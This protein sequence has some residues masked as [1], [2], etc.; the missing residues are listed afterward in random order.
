LLVHLDRHSTGAI[1]VG[2]DCQELAFFE[3]L[4]FKFSAAEQW[5][6]HFPLSLS[7]HILNASATRV[8]RNLKVV[9]LRW[10][11]SA[12]P[13]VGAKVGTD[14]VQN[15]RDGFLNRPHRKKCPPKVESNIL[16]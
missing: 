12:W 13:V 14:W 4:E 1:T 8:H 10:D 7:I 2:K 5:T 6:G 11:F 9:V 3:H 16:V 15:K